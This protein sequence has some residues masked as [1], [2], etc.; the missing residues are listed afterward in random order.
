MTLCNTG[1]RLLGI[2]LECNFENA[3]LRAAVL[4]T[5]IRQRTLRHVTFAILSRSGL[6]EENQSTKAAGQVRYY[7]DLAPASAAGHHLFCLME[8]IGQSNTGGGVRISDS[9]RRSPH[10]THTVTSPV[11]SIHPPLLM[12]SLNGQSEIPMESLHSQADLGMRTADFFDGSSSDGGEDIASILDREANGVEANLIDRGRHSQ[13]KRRASRPL[14]T[15]NELSA[16]HCQSKGRSSRPEGDGYKPLSPVKTPGE[17]TRYMETPETPSTSTSFNGS[18]T[19]LLPGEHGSSPPQDPRP[20][21]LSDFAR[22]HSTTIEPRSEPAYR[23]SSV[24]PPAPVVN[25]VDQILSAHAIAHEITLQSL[26]RDENTLDRTMDAFGNGDRGPLMPAS[27]LFNDPRS[28]GMPRKLSAPDEKKQTP[29]TGKRVHVLPPPI[30]TTRPRPSLPHN[31]V[32]TPYPEDGAELRH[33]DLS[34]MTD[35]VPDVNTPAS[36]AESILTLS[37]R[38]SRPNTRRRVTTIVIPAS[39]THHSTISTTDSPEKANPRT[40]THSANTPDF[41]DQKFFQALQKAHARL[42]GPWRF[43]S[44]RSLKQ[45]VVCGSASRAADSH[46]GWLLSPRSPRELAFKGL[47]D[48]FGEDKLLANY[49]R[50]AMGKSRFA[51]VHWAHRLAAAETMRVSMLPSPLA[52]AQHGIGDQGRE[53][54]RGISG[55]DLVRKAEQPGGLEFVFSW[56]I[57]RLSLALGLVLAASVAATLLWVLLG[58]STSSAGLDVSSSSSSGPGTGSGFRDAGDRVESGLVMGISVLLVSLSAFAGW[59]GVSWLVI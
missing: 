39:S 17:N 45:I 9:P 30:D 4:T 31:L 19:E 27:I 40:Q 3:F 20:A 34:H 48:T 15:P 47:H 36:N 14:A 56:S 2:G 18:I 52:S 26:M 28:P 50:P 41:D 46:Y 5:V 12:E 44:A 7:S 49:R 16:T 13:F 25:T 24:I 59:V 21:R 58:R 11:R 55:P 22:P 8:S 29:G 32:R 33:K 57:L 23:S 38:P 53:Q 1:S 42:S 43:L 51:F 10:V 54:E 37:I 6:R 35:A